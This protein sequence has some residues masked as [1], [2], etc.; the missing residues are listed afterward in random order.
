ME[1]LTRV[2]Q[3]V[4]TKF[5]NLKQYQIKNEMF[6]FISLKYKTFCVFKALSKRMSLVEKFVEF[7]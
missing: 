7:L 5:L 3:N 6:L 2:R 4:E 1:E